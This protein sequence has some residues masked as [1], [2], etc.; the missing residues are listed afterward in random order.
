MTT[1]LQRH[2]AEEACVIPVILRATDW[3]SAP[4][5]K[6]QAL[7]THGKPIASWTERDEAF[8]DVAQGIR[9]VAETLR[10]RRKQKLEEKQSAQD[11]Y[12]Q[13][14]GGDFIFSFGRIS[15]IA[16]RYAHM[17]CARTWG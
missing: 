3:T 6:L 5:G 7:P 11:Q 4:F 16:R 1:A 14:D 8:L 10:A 17:N 15:V 9:E 12:K 2:A 13:E